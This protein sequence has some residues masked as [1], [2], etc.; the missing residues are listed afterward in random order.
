MADVALEALVIVVFLTKD[1]RAD[2]S[3]IGL[4]TFGIADS[5]CLKDANVEPIGLPTFCIIDSSVA[6]AVVE[7]VSFEIVLD[8]VGD[9]AVL[10]KPVAFPVVAS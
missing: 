2:I 8:F 1:P 10:V 7:L 6:I 5:C 9:N 3:G 4:D